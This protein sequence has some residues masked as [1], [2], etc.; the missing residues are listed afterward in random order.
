MTYEPDDELLLDLGPDADL[1]RGPRSVTA[2][3]VRPA[4]TPATAGRTGL[5]EIMD[6]DDEVRRLIEAGAS[7]E[8][9]EAAV[10][11]GMETLREVGLRAAAEDGRRSRRSCARRW[12]DPW[13]RLKRSMARARAVLRRHGGGGAA[14]AARPAR[15]LGG[16]VS[17]GTVTDFTRS[18]RRCP[19]RGSRCVKALRRLEGQTEPGPFKNVLAEITDDVSAGAPLSEAM[20]KHDKAFDEPLYASMVRAG[21]AG[22]ILDRVLDRLARFREKRGHHPREDRRRCSTRAR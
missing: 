10:A 14:T 22:G 12:S 8:D 5:F 19:R 3:D 6:V 7:I 18:S 1:V 16:R 4:T 9:R 2:A 11:G 13:R 15:K 17:S 21:E 20:G